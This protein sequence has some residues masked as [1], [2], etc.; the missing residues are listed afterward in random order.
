MQ[1][2]VGIPVLLILAWVAAERRR[3]IMWR[4]ILGGLLLQ[5]GVGWLVL[6]VSAVRR[7]F[8]WLSRGFVR[9]LDFAHEGA[10]FLFG[11]L[12]RPEYAETFGFIFVLQV[13][14][15]VIFFSALT[16]ALY[17]LGVLQVVVQAAAW[18]M[19]RTLGTSGPESLC[20]ASNI[21]LGQTEAPLLIRPF[22][23]G[24][25]RSELLAIMV[26]GMATL[27][28]GVLAAYV[29]F[30]GGNDPLMRQKFALH[31]MAAS[32][33]NA[34]AALIFAKILLPESDPTVHQKPLKVVSDVSAANLLE[35]LAQGAADGLRLAANIAA[36]LLAFIAAIALMNYL[37]FRLGEFLHLNTWISQSSRGLYPGLSLEWLLGQVFRPVAWLI[38]VDWGE[39]LGVGA[40]IGQKIVINE[41][42]AYT[43]LAQMPALSEKA[44]VISTYALSGFA[45]FSSIAIQLG[46]IGSLAP[47]RRREL[48]ELGLRAVLGG[49][50]ASLLSACWA[51]VFLD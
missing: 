27:A 31:L 30:L 5:A 14:P 22:I 15:T 26:G 20:V 25:S 37:L 13:L 4:V 40:L 47:H 16:A 48:A 46:G 10:E 41:F 34:P 42:I 2:L 8:E 11:N 33:M 39:S 1:V 49:A 24:L 28:G 18:V 7:G 21:F 38:G 43:K 29:G 35:A 6:K 44:R 51:G 45:N 32:V 17:H 3:P 50:F 12:V 36:M 9:V 19:R 23:G